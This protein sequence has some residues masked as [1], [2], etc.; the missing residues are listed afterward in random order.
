[1]EPK[2]E[3]VTHSEIT[4]EPMGERVIGEVDPTTLS[5]EE[6]K[7]SP[8]LLFHGAMT[9]FEFSRNFDYRSAEYY[10]KS[11]GSQTLGE[12]FYTTAERDSA[13]NY[14]E[15][16]QIG[17]VNNP[18]VVEVLPYQAKVLDLRA[19]S[20]PSKTAPVSK[21]FFEKWYGRFKQYYKERSS[22]KNL[23]W[24]VTMAESDYMSYLI[25]LKEA[26][27]SPDLRVMLGTTHSGMPNV[28]N[29]NLPSPPWMKLFSNFMVDEGYDG[30]VYNE[31]GEGKNR[32]NHTSYVFYNLDKVGT[33]KS[34]HESTEASALK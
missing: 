12:G 32:K 5:A 15:V 6:F 28:P 34:W 24:W 8:D 20:D 9:D 16:R 7:S 31:G 29:L 21:E 18:V 19:K 2:L 22:D 25:K 13:E 17:Q 23:P 1:M 33:H 4:L 14:S 10:E 11:D 3:E 27:P 26:K 30:V